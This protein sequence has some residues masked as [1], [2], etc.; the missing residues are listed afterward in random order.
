MLRAIPSWKL[1]YIC[2]V[3]LDKLSELFDKL[4]ENI[5]NTF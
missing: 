1:L 3:E 4:S 5:I 2:G